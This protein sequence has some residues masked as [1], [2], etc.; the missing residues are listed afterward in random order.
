MNNFNSDKITQPEINKFTKE[1]TPS[2]TDLNATTDKANLKIPRLLNNETEDALL[3]IAFRYLF[4][5]N[6]ARQTKAPF[7]IDNLRALEGNRLLKKKHPFNLFYDF[8]FVA[9]KTQIKSYL[10]NNSVTTNYNLRALRIYG[11]CYLFAQLD[12]IAQTGTV[13]DKLNKEFY[14]LPKGSFIDEFEQMN[15]LALNHFIPQ[16]SQ[17]DTIRFFPTF[18]DKNNDFNETT[19]LLNDT[20]VLIDTSENGMSKENEIN[21]LIKLF[22]LQNAK[23]N[24]PSPEKDDSFSQIGI[25]RARYGDMITLHMKE[26]LTS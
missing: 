3:E 1:K 6:I 26:F 5:L 16:L 10:Y 4:H 13:P 24:K 21:T 22:S 7:S 17:K 11:R 14:F 9:A 25:Y 18:S 12:A 15:D 20:L 19:F 2:Y 23:E 8:Q